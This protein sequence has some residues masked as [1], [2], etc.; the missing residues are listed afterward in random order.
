MLFTSESGQPHEN[1]AASHHGA[2]KGSPRSSTAR[3]HA[4]LLTTGSPPVPQASCGSLKPSL[5]P[6]GLG[7]VSAR[8]P[9]PEAEVKTPRWAPRARFGP[10]L[11]ERLLFLRQLPPDVGRIVATGSGAPC[12]AGRERTAGGRLAGGV[13]SKRTGPRGRPAAGDISFPAGEAPVTHSGPNS[14]PIACVSPSCTRGRG[15]AGRRDTGSHSVMT[16]PSPKL[17]VKSL[18]PAPHGSRNIPVPRPHLYL[19]AML[20]TCTLRWQLWFF[21]SSFFFF[22]KTSAL[23]IGW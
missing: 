4:P 8:R 12:Q 18:L 23:G 6:P 2:Q 3:P 17:W 22:P 9:R 21:S 15:R 19:N 1:R 13:L 7:V 10:L 5:R 20:V 11:Q 16:F 14:A